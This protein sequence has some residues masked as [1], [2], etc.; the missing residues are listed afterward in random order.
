MEIEEKR[1]AGGNAILD[2]IVYNP[3]KG[4]L[5]YK[6]VRYLL[7]RP[8]TLA[9]MQKAMER[10]SGT[11]ANEIIFQGGFD[12][13]Y[14]S[15]RKYKE[16]H[17]FRDEEILDFMV[18]MGSQIGWGVFH[19]ALF[20]PVAESICIEVRNSPFAEAYGKA[21]EGVCHLIRGVVSGLATAIFGKNSTAS[22]TNCI[23]KGDEKCS[24]VV[25]GNQDMTKYAD[26]LQGKRILVV[27]DEPDILSTLKEIL[28]ECNIST[29]EDFKKAKKLLAEQ[30]FD[31]AILD[32]MGVNG[33]D[34]LSITTKKNIPTLMLT[35]HA[36][37]PADFVQSVQGGAQAYLPK[38]KISEIEV[39][40]GEIIETRKNEGKKSRTWFARL[41][42]FF[43]ERF[44][45]DWKEKTEPEFWEKYYYL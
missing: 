8:E 1:M 9:G 27:D 35:A 26:I 44:G 25:G 23:A 18:R 14:L 28:D 12:G 40:L 37:S 30:S 41:E 17:G 38:D 36:L 3:D 33:Y 21:S 4:A 43:K 15:A 16:I 2:E 29:A 5:H 22:E 11:E 42:P 32:I 24:F 20:D 39:F 19:L 31:A 10:V 45:A 6:E 34:L 13:G 7:I